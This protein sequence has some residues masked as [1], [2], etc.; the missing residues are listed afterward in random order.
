MTEVKEINAAQRIALSKK[1]LD[2]NDGSPD[3]EHF[4][5]RVTGPYLGGYVGIEWCGMFLGIEQDGYT[6]S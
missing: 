4:L 5:A 2:N 6:H 3:F 1:F